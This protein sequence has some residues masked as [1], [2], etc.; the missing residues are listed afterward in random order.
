MRFNIVYKY[1]YLEQTLSLKITN[2]YKA[3]KRN[4]CISL[5]HSN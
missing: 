3:N 1:K 4:I 5:L 2:M